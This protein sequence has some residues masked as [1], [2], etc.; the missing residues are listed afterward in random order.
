MEIDQEIFSTVILL[1]PLIQE[2][3]LSVTSKSILVYRLVKLA[4]VKIVVMLCDH[5][6]MTI[7]VDW[8]IK[9]QIQTNRGVTQTLY[10]T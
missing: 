2:G 1:L 7:A 9:P 5:L 8:D 10:S 4:K 3:L 6:V